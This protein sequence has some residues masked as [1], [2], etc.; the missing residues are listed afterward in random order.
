MLLASASK[1]GWFANGLDSH[2]YW[3][4][5]FWLY[6]TSII[7]III[8][9]LFVCY[10]NGRANNITVLVCCFNSSIIWVWYSDPHTSIISIH[11]IIF[12]PLCFA[13]LNCATS[14]RRLLPQRSQATR[15]RPSTWPRGRCWATSSSL[16]NLESCKSFKTPFY[17]GTYLLKVVAAI[18]TYWRLGIQLASK[19]WVFVCLLNSH[20]FKN[21]LKVMCK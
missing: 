13:E 18:G 15:R 16:E 3:S 14:M 19:F 9:I 17:T 5:S 2:S 8:P 11:Y 21:Q 4:T 20:H 12:F 7:Q 10:S 6:R 1:R